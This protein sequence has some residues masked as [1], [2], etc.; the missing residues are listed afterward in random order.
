MTALPEDLD[1]VGVHALL[2]GMSEV[3]GI[4]RRVVHASGRLLGRPYRNQPLIGSPDTIEQ[5]TASLAGFDCVTYV[6]SVLALAASRD[7]ADFVEN[8][9]RIRYANGVVDW[10]RRNHYMTDWVRRNVSAGFLSDLTRGVG[11]VERERRLN[12]VDGLP[13]STIQLRS[14]GKASFIRRQSEARFGDLVFFAS[15]R[16][17]LDVFHCGILAGG[18]G[19]F[20]LRHAA[21]S[22]GLVVE[23]GLEDFLGRNRMTGVILVRPKDPFSKAA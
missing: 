2:E 15:T 7:V 17:N 11:L 3:S 5:F 1:R 6:E 21:R 9:R 22:R 8:L 18:P 14:I 13:E 10:K 19:G 23:Q 20:G 16:R 4:A 12:V